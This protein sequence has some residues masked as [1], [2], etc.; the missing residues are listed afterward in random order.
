MGVAVLFTPKTDGAHQPKAR[1]DPAT[2]PALGAFRSTVTLPSAMTR[3]SGLAAAML[4]ASLPTSMTT[5]IGRDTPA[6]DTA[7]ELFSL[8]LT[9]KRTTTRATTCGLLL[10][11][12]PWKGKAFPLSRTSKTASRTKPETRRSVK[13]W[14]T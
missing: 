9:A 3:G 2:E 6:T 5:A 10:A 8:L 4:G 11:A 12:E 1:K 13:T 7:S 14:L